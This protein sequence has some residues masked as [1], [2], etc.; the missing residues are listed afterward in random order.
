MYSLL[1]VEVSWDL[2]HECGYYRAGD[3]L[4]NW[5]G[6]VLTLLP[7]CDGQKAE[8]ESKLWIY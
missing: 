5:C 6:L 4:R 2:A 1:Y 8:P 3:G 7:G